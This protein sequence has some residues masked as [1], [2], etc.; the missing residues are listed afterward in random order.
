MEFNINHFI[1]VVLFLGGLMGWGLFAYSLISA[2]CCRKKELKMID[3][4]SEDLK[5]VK[6]DIQK[7]NK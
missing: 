6:E 3:I 4:I 5:K 7:L 2:I 1:I